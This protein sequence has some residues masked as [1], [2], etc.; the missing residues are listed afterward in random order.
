MVKNKYTIEQIIK[1]FDNNEILLVCGDSI[2]DVNLPEVDENWLK[3][4]D[5]DGDIK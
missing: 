1:F 2:G 5:K 4:C 3:D